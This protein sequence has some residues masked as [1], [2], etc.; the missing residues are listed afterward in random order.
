MNTILLNICNYV[1]NTWRRRDKETFALDERVKD[2]R[3]LHISELAGNGEFEDMPSKFRVQDW[4]FQNQ[5]V[6]GYKMS[7]TAMSATSAINNSHSIKK[8]AERYDWFGLFDTAVDLD[9][10]SRTKWAYTI[11][12]IKLTKALWYI[13]RYY[14]VDTVIDIKL[15]LYKW[16]NVCTGSNKIDWNDCRIDWLVKGISK[17]SG[18]AFPIVW[19]DDE[20]AIWNYQWCFR[21]ENSYWKDYMDEWGFWIPYD[22]AIQVLH[23][24]KKALLT[25]KTTQK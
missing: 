21:C 18:H 8:R 13:L 25:K 22:I 7:C 6:D 20:K 23:N 14:Q 19:W 10:A 2:T 12:L 16:L 4:V 3:D 15:A 9:L 24:T 5:F 11:H 1:I 17:W